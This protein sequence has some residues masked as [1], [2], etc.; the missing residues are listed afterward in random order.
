M[1]VGYFVPAYRQNEHAYLRMQAVVEERASVKAGYE[2]SPWWIDCGD[3][4]QARRIALHH[5]VEHGH[6]Y[7][8]MQDSDIYVPDGRSAIV[9]M[10]ETAQKHNAAAVAAICGLR[11][12]RAESVQPNVLPFKPGEVYEA[13]KAGTGLMLIDVGWVRERYDE[14]TGPWFERTWKDERHLQLDTGED[15][16][17]CKIV[18]AM[19]G[20]LWVD[21]RVHTVH[22]YTDTMHLRYPPQDST[23]AEAVSSAPGSDSPLAVGTAA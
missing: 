15:I 8:L 5:S 1:K 22:A 9:P 3:I 10:L 11:R 23:D 18:R 17:F 13:E 16:F 14:Y 4:A 21:G 12:I 19:G 20:S 7:L 2:V 6:D